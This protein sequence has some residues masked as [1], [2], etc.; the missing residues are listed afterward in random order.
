M[1][2]LN[3]CHYSSCCTRWNNHLP[4]KFVPICSAVPPLMKM[5]LQTQRYLK[6][7]RH[8]SECL[9]S[10][11]IFMSMT[12]PKNICISECHLSA[13]V[14]L[15]GHDL[16]DMVS[17]RRCRSTQH[18]PTLLWQLWIIQQHSLNRKEEK[19]IFSSVLSTCLLAAL[20]ICT[21]PMIL[22]SSDPTFIT[23]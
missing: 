9:L 1:D 4:R 2:A 12:A 21:F 20:W 5:W 7:I 15:F 23:S 6:L 16:T 14:S 11:L 19:P 10:L 17:V 3:P 13:V 18:R 8:P 22:L